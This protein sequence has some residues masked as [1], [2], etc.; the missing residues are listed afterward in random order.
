MVCLGD[1][2]DQWQT[3]TAIK[4]L[5]NSKGA[6]IC[7]PISS[8]RCKVFLSIQ[9]CEQTHAETYR[10]LL[11]FTNQSVFTLE[12]VAIHGLRFAPYTSLC[13][14]T[15]LTDTSTSQLQRAHSDGLAFKLAKPVLPGDETYKGDA[16][17]IFAVWQIR[18]TPDKKD[19][20]I[21]FVVHTV[22][23]VTFWVATNVKA[24][25]PFEPMVGWFDQSAP[26]TVEMRLKAC[27]YVPLQ[28]QCSKQSVQAAA[29]KSAAAPKSAAAA[30]SAAAKSAGAKRNVAASGSQ[31]KKAR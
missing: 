11:G 27:T 14:L 18:L 5:E 19:A 12:N 15:E 25:T 31:P 8:A 22:D 1:F 20:N 13:K 10:G 23:D 4:Q 17:A 28:R 21:G 30:K 3:D 2:C 7:F 16:W 29:G 24:L 6:D 9:Q 26:A